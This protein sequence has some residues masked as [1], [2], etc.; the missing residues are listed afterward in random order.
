M[1]ANGLELAAYKIEAIILNR[2]RNFDLLV[3]PMD[4]HTV[5]VKRSL[6]Y[7]GII[8]NFTFTFRRTLADAPQ[9]DSNVAMALGRLMLNMSGLERKMYSITLGGHE[10]INVRGAPA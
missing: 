9:R 3:I 8:L 5:E 4:G 2:R 6:K 7:L 10:L 1:R